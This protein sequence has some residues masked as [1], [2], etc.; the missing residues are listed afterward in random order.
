MKLSLFAAARPAPSPVF[1]P[2]KRRAFTLIELLVVIAIIAILAAILFPVFAQARDKARATAC[3]SNSKQLATAMLMYAQDYD[4]LMVSAWYG[5]QGFRG[6]DPRIPRYKWMDAVFPYIKNQQVFTCPSMDTQGDQKRY[7][8]YLN[9]TGSQIGATRHYGSFSINI[10]YWG[11][12]D[13]QNGPAGQS[14]AS[15]ALPADTYWA[16]E[17]D[18]NYETA[19]QNKN[20]K[21]TKA[22][23]NGMPVFQILPG[24]SNGTGNKVYARHM[25]F[26]NI[27]RCASFFD[28]CSPSPQASEW[29]C[30]PNHSGG[31]SWTWT[32]LL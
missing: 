26:A 2:D 27:T 29:R 19:W 24:C 22:L 10:A 14:L 28:S 31:A 15:L 4:E 30:Q 11:G 13:A 20:C 1:F 18:G 9:R 5:P 6:P 8:Y 7:I 21:G 32:S 3:L 12:G 16:M 23:V 17:G 25:Q